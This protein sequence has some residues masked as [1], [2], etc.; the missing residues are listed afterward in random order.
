MI[1]ACFTPS[2]NEGLTGM[3]V[4]PDAGRTSV[5]S[6]DRRLSGGSN[7]QQGIENSGSRSIAHSGQSRLKLTTPG[8][9]RL[10][11]QIALGHAVDELV[12]AASQL[13]CIP[14]PTDE[15]H[16]E[17]LLDVVSRL[18]RFSRDLTR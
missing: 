5:S 15:A 3:T 9:R 18:R 1:R 8:E 14:N 6:G 16:A 10:K 12:V 13:R 7:P 17:T 2:P 4:T 11:A